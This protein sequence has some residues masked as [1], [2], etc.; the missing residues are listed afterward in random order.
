MQRVTANEII[1]D[2]YI[3]CVQTGLVPRDHSHNSHIHQQ[4][5]EDP[6]KLFQASCK[7]ALDQKIK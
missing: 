5:F 4:A 1:L 6:Y 3:P 2:G 7:T